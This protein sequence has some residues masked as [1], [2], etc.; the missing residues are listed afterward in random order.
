MPTGVPVELLA[1]IQSAKMSQTA[2]QEVKT[3]FSDE[4]SRYLCEADCRL[5]WSVSA[6]GCAIFQ[7]T[8]VNITAKAC[9]KAES[10]QCM[11]RTSE[12]LDA[13]VRKLHY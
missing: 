8:S 13:L 6:C 12:L 5:Q 9:L 4:Y 2:G 1:E 11:V 7:V 10:L 3:T